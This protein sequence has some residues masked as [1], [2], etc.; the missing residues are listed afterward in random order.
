M[1]F[2]D[3]IVERRGLSDVRISQLIKKQLL[4]CFEDDVLPVDRVL[5]EIYNEEFCQGESKTKK[6]TPFKG[7]VL[8]D[9]WHVHFTLNNFIPQN[10]R[11]E[12]VK[13]S[14]KKD[15]EVEINRNSKEADAYLRAKLLTDF[16]LENTHYKRSRE[17]RLT[18]EWIIFKKHNGINYYLTLALHDEGDV[19]IFDRIKNNCMLEYPDIF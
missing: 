16:I 9:F 6:S 4:C 10:M 7:D 3:D 17:S 14:F 19:V 5:D 15:L 18:G 13:S 8:K 12:M 2:I 11:I 1:S